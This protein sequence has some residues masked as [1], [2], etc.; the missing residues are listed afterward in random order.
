MQRHEVRPRSVVDDASVRTDS[1]PVPTR[2]R[3]SW[4]PTR[5][6][7]PF[8]G[9]S[10]W[11]RP[12]LSSLVLGLVLAIVA[13]PTSNTRLLVT[14]GV[15][16]AWQAAVTMA[17]HN[18]WAFG[19]R[20]IFTYGPL[21]FLASP[22]LFFSSTAI[23]A[24]V[25]TLAF[26]TALY[27]AL[28]WTLRRSI[29]LPLAAVV[30]YVVGG[31]SFLSAQYFGQDIAI[32]DVLALV[33][34]VC[35]SVLSRPRR[36]GVPV[37]IWVGLGGVLSIFSLVKA[38]LA[39]GIGVAIVITVIFLPSD[40][41][42]A[43]GALALGAVPAFCLGWFG[44]GNG[45]GNLIGFGRLSADV[46][47]GYGSAMSIEDPR[48]GYA[49]WLAAFAVVVIGA[50]ALAH[51]RPLARRAQVGVGLVTV[52]I[53]WFLFKEGFV[54]H[55]GHDVVFFVAAPLVLA[56]FSPP[57]R[58]PA[59]LVAAILGL[60][61]VAASVGGGVP[62]LVTHPYQGVRN[63]F[64]NATTLASSHKRAEAVAKS[65]RILSRQFQ[66]PDAMVNV[67]RGQTVDVS[68]WEQTVVWVY[69]GV[70]FDPLPVVQDYNAYTPTLDQLDTNFLRSSG[71]PRFILRQPLAIDG[72]NPA[73]EPPGTQLAIECRYHEVAADP[74]WQLLERQANR[75]GRRHL[76]GTVTTGL[77]HWVTVPSAPGNDAVVA[78]FQLP[79]GL[80]SKLESL[81]YKPPNVFMA[82]N[83]GQ[84][85]WRFV[86]ATGPDLHVLRP[87]SV[88]GYS[89]PF[90]PL[91][92]TRVRFAID[93]ESRTKSGLKISFYEIPM[94]KGS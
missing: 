55:D 33:L 23:L 5:Q 8:L 35:V 71:A 75:C 76:V 42:R 64:D 3:A 66:L 92:S 11:E 46:I 30:A 17:T 32:E 78:S 50:F 51:A 91:T 2:R 39:V 56:A 47:G 34:I 53:L 26:S 80:G 9:S 4:T 93:G 74:A 83:N 45:F 43:V 49:Y 88:L 82:V 37:W 73:F 69:P 12:I 52:A 61:I 84:T 70:H 68:P 72:R 10:L 44:T 6:Q 90:V 40:R 87:S 89:Q 20:V 27:T 86:P 18:H 13:W 57:W 58:S 29:P 15:A 24:F 85:T 63:F 81:I 22:D 62:A 14:G 67:M 60:T 31:V 7:L 79:E 21:G 94:E 28:V 48:R 59:W 77:G 38:S 19:T 16:P 65:R 36:D 1:G 54:R 25:F 41:R